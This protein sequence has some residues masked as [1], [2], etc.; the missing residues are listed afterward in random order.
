MGIALTIVWGLA[1]LAIL[2]LSVILAITL[3]RNTTSRDRVVQDKEVLIFE[4][5]EDTLLFSYQNECVRSTSSGQLI[6][7]I[8][9]I[10][11]DAAWQDDL[12]R[13]HVVARDPQSVVLGKVWNG[14]QKIA[15]YEFKAYR[16]TDLGTDLP[17]SDFVKPIDIIVVTTRAD[18]D[19]DILVESENGWISAPKV[20]VALIREHVSGKK[21]WALASVNRLDRLCL[22]ETA[23][24]LG[25]DE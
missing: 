20:D 16:M 19:F 3:R 7:R 17:V 9:G 8:G 23:H 24:Q 1:L 13:I 15:A 22:I 10:S 14:A 2:I 21:R 12:L 6:I 11:W 25:P 5:F 4:P 18:G